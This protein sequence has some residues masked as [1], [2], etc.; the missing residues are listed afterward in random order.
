MVGATR[1]NSQYSAIE[2]LL[3][4]G[5]FVGCVAACGTL[6]EQLMTALYLGVMG[7][8][9]PLSV[10][11]SDI[12]FWAVI[13]DKTF[14]DT[15]GMLHYAC[16]RLTEDPDAEAD[17]RRAAELAK[18][19]LDEVIELTADF[20]SHHGAQRCL[21]PRILKNGDARERVS[22]LVESLRAQLDGAGCSDGLSMQPPFMNACLLDFS[23]EDAA[24]WA[25][26]IAVRL[27]RIGLL[28]T[29][30]V[31]TLDAEQVVVE[32]VGL[33]NEFIRR[34]AA[35]ANGGALLIEHMEE[36]DMPCLGGNLLDRAF[37]TTC[38]AAEKYLGSL[39]IV[40]SGEGE[41]VE[42]AFRS[43][44]QCAEYFPLVLS[45]KRS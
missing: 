14:C 12:A 37:K 17:P 26:H 16:Q 34:A 4:K 41:R 10:I 20:L 43:S 29:A 19:G 39:C 30:E 11:L 2:T 6:F 32:R 31:H 44:E 23:D 24:L 5:A 3:E 25:R 42:K 40:V 7:E 22:R 8:D 21:D 33:T 28:T 9:E 15:A 1:L 36:F 13:G 18:S 35:Q 27:Q 45:G 38:T